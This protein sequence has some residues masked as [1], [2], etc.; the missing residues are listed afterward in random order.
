M[1]EE[2]FHENSVHHSKEKFVLYKKGDD[3]ERISPHRKI[4]I[5]EDAYTRLG[6]WTREVVAISHRRYDSTGSV[7]GNPVSADLYTTD[8]IRFEYI[9]FEL[10]KSNGPFTVRRETSYLQSV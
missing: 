10:V 1:C 9:S 5:L 4:R 8:T 3:I 6:N 2:R 7:V